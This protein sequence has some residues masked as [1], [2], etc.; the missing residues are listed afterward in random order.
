MFQAKVLIIGGD[1]ISEIVHEDQKQTLRQMTDVSIAA[2]HIVNGTLTDIEH[3]A[4]DDKTLFQDKDI[5]VISAGGH[6]LAKP[7][8][9]E[10][11]VLAA[12]QHT[13]NKV[14]SISLF[15]AII[16]LYL[17][18][19]SA[20]GTS[21]GVATYNDEVRRIN[22]M[23]KILFEDRYRIGVG[24]L[25]RAIEVSN[26][27]EDGIKLSY[28]SLPVYIGYVKNCIEQGKQLLGL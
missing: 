24:E 19:R 16:V 17:L 15:S 25:R 13:V 23:M 27:R 20:T 5:I 14:R 4:D 26:L 21:K 3:L 11:S 2:C 10:S 9:I 8:Q 1:H 22:K 12:M 7:E 18:P 6:D 28:G